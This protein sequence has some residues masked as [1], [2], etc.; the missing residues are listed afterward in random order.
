MR[1]YLAVSAC[2][3][4]AQS[5]RRGVHRIRAQVGKLL[6]SARGLSIAATSALRNCAAIGA[7]T[8]AGIQMLRQFCADDKSL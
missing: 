3:V 4:L 8:P 2:D 6:A 5:V 7:G 1:L